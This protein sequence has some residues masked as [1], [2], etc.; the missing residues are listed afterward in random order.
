MAFTV[1]AIYYN[2]LLFGAFAVIIQFE[3]LQIIRLAFPHYI[4]AHNN[5]E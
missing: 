5:I 2:L 4:Y 1:P 3:T